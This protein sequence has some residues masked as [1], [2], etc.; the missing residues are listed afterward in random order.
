MG[1]DVLTGAGA[2]AVDQL[3]QN[4]DDKRAEE[5]PS[6]ETLGITR[7][8]GTYLNYGVPILAIAASAMGWLRGDWAT[9]AV[10]AGSQLAGRKV[11]WQVT[12]RKELP[13]YVLFTPSNRNTQLEAQK[14]AKQLETARREA[15]ARARSVGAGS[16]VHYDITNEA[17]Y[18]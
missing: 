4:Q 7:Q 3:I 9:R 1:M 17:L 12:K 14:K 18:T 13:G 8:Y 6:G 15:E 11:V 10:L 2:G 5:L 16:Q